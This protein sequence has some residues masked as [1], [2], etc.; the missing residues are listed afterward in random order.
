M[1]MGFAYKKKKYE[2]FLEWADATNAKCFYCHDKENAPL[3]IT[4]IHAKGIC[5]SC[6]SQ[7][8]IGHLETD[9]HVIAEI[10]PSFQT[11]QEALDWFRQFGPVHFVNVVGEDG[12]DVFIYHFVHDPEKYALYTQTL[13]DVQ[14]GVS[15]D[16]ETIKKLAESYSSLEIHRNGAYYIV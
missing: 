11:R 5:Q 4:F 16:E 10:A 7:F 8:E 2:D 3:A 9:R 6:L 14:N 12:D 1:A 13:E 15:D